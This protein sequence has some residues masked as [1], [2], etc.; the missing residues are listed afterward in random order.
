MKTILSLLAISAALFA[1]A[2]GTG[3][4]RRVNTYNATCTFSLSAAATAMTIQ[5]PASGAKTVRFI[6]SYI[7]SDA[8]ITLKQER[9]GTTA[10][11]TT[12]TVRKQ[13]EAAT[14]TA[15]AWCA[16]NA[17]SGTPVIADD[18][19]QIPASS[20]QVLDLSS[21]QM[22]GDGIAVNF[23]IRI[24]TATANGAMVITWEEWD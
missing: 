22:K 19:V 1:Q 21:I 5:Q 6:S 18:A 12:A 20:P 10:S 2:P 14:A 4:L 3:P 15:T 17:G 9:N 8:A 24:S 23:T 11:A 16:S 13:P 7:R